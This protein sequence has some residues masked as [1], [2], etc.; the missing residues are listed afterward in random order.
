MAKERVVVEDGKAKKGCLSQVLAFIGVLVSIL[1]L[2]N[3]SMGIVEIPDNLPFI[4]N[5]DEV[6]V[7]GFLFA[8]LRYLGIDVARLSRR[9]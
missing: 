6:V 3:L 2:L 8:C 1:Y 7:S 4:G 5:V 9:R